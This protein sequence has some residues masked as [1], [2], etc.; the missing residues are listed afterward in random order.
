MKSTYN[1]N[2]SR[3]R[4]RGAA[5]LIASLFCA[6]PAFA[7]VVNFESLPASANLSG[8]TLSEAGYNM[9][10]VEG[11]LAAG[12]GLVGATGV[13]IDSSNPF[14]CDIIACPLGASGNYLAV[15]NDGAVQLSHPGQ[16]SGFSLTGFDFAFMPPAPVPVG[17]YGQLQLTGMN[18]QGTTISTR[19]DFPAQNAQGTFLFGSADLSAAFR[20]NVFSSLTISA[21]LFDG[22]G[23][24]FNSFDNPAFNQAQ[25]GI[26][27]LNLTA[28]PEPG[29]FLLFG[30]GMGALGLA[31]RRAARRAVS[32]TS[33]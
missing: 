6:A 22:Q 4:L 26:D 8:E 20:A 28:V 3:P 24:C 5:V 17:S 13:I 1:H 16:L 7:D 9:L 11:P 12:Y 30:L 14:S 15:V 18:W 29:S 21:C 2:T 31:R 19:L 32:S 25:F 27:N 33:N 23:G 10:L